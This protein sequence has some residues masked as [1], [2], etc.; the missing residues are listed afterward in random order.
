MLITRFCWHS[1][2]AALIGIQEDRA[3]TDIILRDCAIRLLQCAL[4]TAC[5]IFAAEADAV[6]IFKD[7][8]FKDYS[9]RT[10]FSSAMVLF[11]STR[12]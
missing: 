3:A 2:K 6:S 4:P 10:I 12:R 7:I 1:L 5:A 9:Q 8:N 11:K